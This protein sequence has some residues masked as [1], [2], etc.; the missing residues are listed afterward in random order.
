MVLLMTLMNE[1]SFF[2]FPQNLIDTIRLDNLFMCL[3]EKC[4]FQQALYTN[5]CIIIVTVE[6]GT[7]GSETP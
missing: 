4:V 5:C 2:F 3:L 6:P 1:L 7:W